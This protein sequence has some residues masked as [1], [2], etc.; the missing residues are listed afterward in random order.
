MFFQ[1]ISSVAVMHHTSLKL[2][3]AAFFRP[4]VPE[5]PT[6]KLSKKKWVSAEEIARRT[7]PIRK[8]IVP[9]AMGGTGMHRE[10]LVVPF[11]S[12]ANVPGYGSIVQQSTTHKFAGI[13]VTFHELL[14]PSGMS[15]YGDCKGLPSG[16]T[17]FDFMDI[18]IPEYWEPPQDRLPQNG[19]DGTPQGPWKLVLRAVHSH[20]TEGH[21]ARLLPGIPGCFSISRVAVS[22][23]GYEV[24]QDVGLE[25]TDAVFSILKNLR[26]GDPD[27][28]LTG[29]IDVFK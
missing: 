13:V 26:K 7:Q 21:E 15:A 4:I 17:T 5:P 8:L 1:L 22:A 28:M 20:H 27:Y 14:V 19:D 24:E 9:S 23:D 16:T 12:N 25:F 2:P 3:S 6:Q 11:G 29:R 10:L 18:N